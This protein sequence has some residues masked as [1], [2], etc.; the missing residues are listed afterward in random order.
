MARRVSPST[1]TL[2][3]VT[4]WMRESMVGWGWGLGAGGWGLGTGGW[5]RGTGDWGLGTRSWG[6]GTGGWG[7]RAGRFGRRE[8]T[9]G[10]APERTT[11]GTFAQTYYADRM[12]P[13]TV[14]KKPD[15]Y[16]KI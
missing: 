7:A 5:G 10:L 6:R 2:A 4:R 12:R 13:D 16:T 8:G 15:I 11:T 14:H 3:E 1:V 9:V